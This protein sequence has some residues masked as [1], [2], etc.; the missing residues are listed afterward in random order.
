MLQ[1]KPLK[2]TIDPRRL[3]DFKD[4][5]QANVDIASNAAEL[6]KLRYLERKRKLNG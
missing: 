6:A 3:N 1:N 2:D 5:Q 4:V